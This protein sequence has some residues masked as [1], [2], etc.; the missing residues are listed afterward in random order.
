MDCSSRLTNQQGLKMKPVFTKLCPACLAR[1]FK[2]VVGFMKRFQWCL[3][4]VFT[5]PLTLGIFYLIRALTNVQ[6]ETSLTVWCAMLATLFSFVLDM[7]VLWPTFD[8]TFH[9]IML[10]VVIYTILLIG[11]M[12][13]DQ[14]KFVES[15]C[16]CSNA[17]NST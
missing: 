3:W 12:N 6:L 11:R 2:S 15:Q 10:W 16:A 14:R 7:V 17:T 8:S 9:S 1:S 4:C 5:F 13:K